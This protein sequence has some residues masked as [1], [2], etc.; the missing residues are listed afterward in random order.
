MKSL[1]FLMAMLLSVVGCTK[2]EPE[3]R[4]EVQ[5]EPSSKIEQAKP[6]NKDKTIYLAPTDDRGIRCKDTYGAIT[7]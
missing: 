6:V 3:F 4:N 7:C 5:R 1:T 2:N